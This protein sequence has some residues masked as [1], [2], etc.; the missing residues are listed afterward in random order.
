MSGEQTAPVLISVEEVVAQ[1]DIDASITAPDVLNIPTNAT[2]IDLYSV[3]AETSL[4]SEKPFR[5]TLRLVKGEHEVEVRA[6]FDGGAMVGALCSTVFERVKNI[7]RGWAPSAVYLRMANGNTVKSRAQWS[8]SLQLGSVV[9]DGVF[10]VFDSQGGWEFLLG[11]PLLRAF[12]AIH[13]F[14]EDQ[15]LI[16]AG[17]LEPPLV[18]HNES[19][20]KNQ[21]EQGNLLG[22]SSGTKPPPRQ[23]NSVCFPVA[24]EQIDKHKDTDSCRSSLEGT[25]E[26]QTEV[27]IQAEP[28]RGDVLGDHT[29][30][31]SRGVSTTPHAVAEPRTD[32]HDHVTEPTYVL[33]QEETV[34]TCHTDPFKPGRVSKILA[35]VRIGSDITPEQR[36]E[37]EHVLAKFTDCFALGLSEVNAVPGAVH[38]L[39]IPEGATFRT[40]VG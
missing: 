33:Q 24:E 14:E 37:V 35:E 29:E 15:V 10:E 22:G 30:S 3:G 28:S 34:F 11:K 38:K 40:R 19:I 1:V 32:T 6:L 13:D 27:L 31:P 23:V 8:G 2:V 16:R 12:R 17:Q 21:E 4:H 39:N 36:V 7:L 9:V 18:L 25:C 26:D 20:V 5:H